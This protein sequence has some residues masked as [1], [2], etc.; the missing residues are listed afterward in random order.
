MLRNRFISRDKT[1]EAAPPAPTTG[2]TT[3]TPSTPATPNQGAQ[4]G[5]DKNTQGS[6]S[7][8]KNK[9][10]D[11]NKTENT[12]TAVNSGS[13]LNANVSKM[14][15]MRNYL[16]SLSYK[17][18]TENKSEQESVTKAGSSEIIDIINDYPWIVDTVINHSTKDT[19]DF[20][21]IETGASTAKSIKYKK[22]T[23]IPVCYITERKSAV[24]STVANVLSLISTFNDITQVI[25]EAGD[26]VS[27]TQ[28]KAGAKEASKLLANGKTMINN[29]IKDSLPGFAKLLAQNNLNDEILNP[30]RFFYITADTGKRYAF[31]LTNK[32]SS[33][34][35]TSKATWG[36]PKGG[37][38]GMIKKVL[39]KVGSV[40]T[41]ASGY[42]NL[43]RNIAYLNNDD[44]T[45]SD[46]NGNAAET[47]KSFTYPDVGESININFTLYNTTKRNAWKNNFRFLYL[48]AMR[49]L[50]FKTETISFVPPL[51]Y[52]IIVPGVKRLPVCAL[53]NMKVDPMGMTRVLECPNFID[54]KS[55]DQ[56]ANGRTIPVNVPEAWSITLTFQSLI[57]PS[58]NLLLAN[59]VGKIGIQAALD[60][61]EMGKLSE[62]EMDETVKE[63]RSE[64]DE[65]QILCENLKKSEEFDKAIEEI[66]EARGAGYSDQMRTHVFSVLNK[67]S[68]TDFKTHI[69]SGEGIDPEEGAYVY[70]AKSDPFLVNFFDEMGIELTVENELEISQY[71]GSLNTDDDSSIINWSRGNI[72]LSAPPTFQDEAVEACRKSIHRTNNEEWAPKIRRKWDNNIRKCIRKDNGDYGRYE[73][74]TGLA[75]DESLLSGDIAYPEWYISTAESEGKNQREEAQAKLD[76]YNQKINSYNASAKEGGVKIDIVCDKTKPA[77]TTT[78]ETEQKSE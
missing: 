50:P 60:F 34:F 27:S 3:S 64:H 56:G 35:I 16:L 1:P 30:Y 66:P 36:K 68:E 44:P 61:G 20:Q 54:S 37:Q 65:M 40:L 72:I 21:Q 10:G 78:S 73:A 69:Y 70:I 17:F 59:T 28:L 57:A 24:N 46:D 18:N 45:K 76:E 71:I 51:L 77:A 14:K 15:D 58:A 75:Y 62:S 9:E 6:P 49:N 23:N 31:P 25:G 8:G 26:A 55:G 47:I 22:K 11:K 42:A 74:L 39:D 5:A 53:T 67:I 63:I 43:A 52:D 13:T 7:S 41:N 2:G 29:F 32:E 19:L 48:F 4:T 33:S 38:T 12:N